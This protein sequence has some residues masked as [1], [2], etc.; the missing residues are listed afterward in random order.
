MSA[1]SS[2]PPIPPNEAARLE[3]L[4]NFCALDTD[5][6]PRLDHLVQLATR[7]LECPIA[8]VSLLDSDR[9]WFKA[10]IGLETKEMPRRIAFCAYAILD[11]DVMI[12]EDALVDPRFV[13]NPLV[14]DPPYIRFYA[15]APLIS[16][17]GFRLG[18][19]CVIDQRPRTFSDAQRSLLK[20]LAQMAVDTLDLHRIIQQTRQD[21]LTRTRF[22]S[23]LSHELR[24]PLNAIMGFSEMILL[25]SP[26]D[27]VA[28]YARAI[29][30]GGTG[31]LQLVD[32]ILDYGQI[33][34]GERPLRLE[35][36]DL[37][38]A[39]LAAVRQV[40]PLADR[41][42][43][44]LK[45]AL[46]TLLTVRADASALDQVLV[47]LLENALKFTRPNGTV[48]VAA[49]K[50]EA[51]GEEAWANLTIADTGIGISP[52]TL[53]KLGDP[54][55]RPDSALTSSERGA[56]LG[57]ALSRRLLQAMGGSVAFTSKPDHGTRVTLRLKLVPGGLP[58]VAEPPTR[59]GHGIDP[60]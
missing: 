25:Q 46:P 37:D 52:E 4:H 30:Q 5:D 10:K 9:Q 57:I 49:Q 33:E 48:K 41:R 55:L 31:L 40:R 60:A 12:V 8:L 22:L 1:F 56:G 7:L 39:I 43:V 35:A 11:D 42:R 29:H 44:S 6:D 17:T 21:N 50:A 15:G 13:G 24:T 27:R 36:L 18:T 19:L 20:E 3:E 58:S 54:F 51:W 32:D 59:S 2:P 45:L 53:A 34:A 38:G 16:E 14:S 28:D 23:S 26:T 47:H